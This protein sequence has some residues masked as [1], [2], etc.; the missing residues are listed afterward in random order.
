MKMFDEYLKEFLDYLRTEKGLSENTVKAY[1]SD[2]QHFANFYCKTENA[3]LSSLSEK[4]L[5][6]FFIQIQDSHLSGSSIARLFVSLK[7]FFRFLCKERYMSSN[8][9]AAM[10]AP[11]IWQTIPEILTYEEV[12]QLLSQPDQTNFIG[13]RDAAVFE[14]LYATGMRVSEVCNLGLYDVGDDTVRVSGKGGN[15]RIVPINEKAIEAIDRYLTRFY[16]HS[17]K[18]DNPPLFV[19]LRGKRIE[20][21]LVWKR[22]KFYGKMAGIEKT[23]SPHTLRHSFA[24]HLLENDADLRVIQELLGHS[25]ITTTERY[26]HMSQKTLQSTFAKFHPR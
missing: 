11:A 19:S 10:S 7:V 9:L 22:V 4:I 25:H 2:I 12:D 23:I 21:T 16:M 14:V 24:T 8:T 5:T 1:S 18:A 6:S 26:T 13:A 17:S 3:L 15:Q 20:R